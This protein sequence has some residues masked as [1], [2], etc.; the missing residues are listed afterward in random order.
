[1]KLFHPLRWIIRGLIGGSGAFLFGR[2]IG[3]LGMIPPNKL[4]IFSHYL[5]F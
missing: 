5:A 2:W 1:V 3:L 4:T